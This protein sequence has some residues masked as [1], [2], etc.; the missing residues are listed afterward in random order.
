[1]RKLGNPSIT[2]R[3]LHRVSV[4]HADSISNYI[5]FVYLRIIDLSVLSERSDD[6][7]TTAATPAT[8][9]Y[10]APGKG[11]DIGKKDRGS[12]VKSRVVRLVNGLTMNRVMGSWGTIYLCA[13]QQK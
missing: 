1:M 7:T 10:E 6:D 12:P 9:S 2:R 8:T 3:P 11:E 13:F 5:R 4:N